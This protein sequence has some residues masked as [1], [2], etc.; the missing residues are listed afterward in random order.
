M[1]EVERETLVEQLDKALEIG[2]QVIHDTEGWN[3][4]YSDEYMKGS[5]KAGKEALYAAKIIAKIP[6]PARETVDRFK[7]NWEYLQETF[8]GV[9]SKSEILN[10]FG[11]ILLRKESLEFG[12]ASAEMYHVYGGREVDGKLVEIATSAFLESLPVE[13]QFKLLYLVLVFE[14]DQNGGTNLTAAFEMGI[15]GPPNE[16]MMIHAKMTRFRFYS[17]VV[18][19][20]S[21]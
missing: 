5:I 20:L 1:D 17:K 11:G 21:N 3:E 12:A 13:R 9:V 6:K 19:F 15:P 16:E 4:I 14:D 8:T 18:E 7:A 2:L 10:E